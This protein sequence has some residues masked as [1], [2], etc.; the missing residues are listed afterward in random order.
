MKDV[1]LL[2]K[3]FLK[4]SFT[5][6]NK[7]NKIKT[8]L[9]YFLS[10][11]FIAFY[12]AIISYQSMIALMQINMQNSFL[13]VC[14]F[15]ILNFL[16]FQNII[17]SINMMFF[18]KDIEY[19]L[20]LPVSSKK[21]LLAKFN[22]LLISEYFLTGIMLLPAL[23]VYGIILNYGL[24]YYLISIIVFFIFP[25]IPIMLVVLILSIIMR[26]T[27][28]IKNRE[29]SQY[30]SI[31]VTL[32]LIFGVLFLNGNSEIMDKEL[33]NRANTISEEIIILKQA[34]QIIENYNNIEGI[35]NLLILILETIIISIINFYIISK[36]YI[37]IVSN[38]GSSGKEKLEIQH[39][40]KKLKNNNIGISY[41]KKEFKI[42]CNNSVFFL[43]CILPT[44][45]LPIII[46]MPLVISVHN[47][48]EDREILLE[49]FKN[50]KSINW[51]CIR[52]I[53]LQ[54]LFT[55]NF[56]STTAISRDGKNAYVMKYIPVSL[57][58]QLLYKIVP[59]VIT[60]MFSIFAILLFSFYIDNVYANMVIALLILGVLLNILMSYLLILIDLKR[61]KLDWTSEYSVVKQNLNMIFNIII[62]V[63]FIVVILI[64]AQNAQS[65]YS[66]CKNI[67]ILVTVTL[68]LVDFI[69]RKNINKL[70]ENI[71]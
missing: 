49:I 32:I 48:Y 47:G 71:I 42:L 58:K 64:T 13:P 40:D 14:F 18:S 31:I 20:P 41:I 19:V 52:L 43:Q 25:I 65:I 68:I 12:I 2:T 46:L 15:I 37:K 5:K 44:I 60:N 4:N 10:Y 38:I 70:F 45:I 7:S 55:F 54:I 3:I 34:V 17:T 11:G 53:L 6:N 57:H 28:F 67:F 22:C 23:I 26:F 30:L 33:V 35:R 63:L 21:I 27:N 24:S 59:N 39:I 1:F 29:F 51:I 9:I 36:F 66:F 56:I 61:P 69:V 62:S 16:I 50:E 8:F